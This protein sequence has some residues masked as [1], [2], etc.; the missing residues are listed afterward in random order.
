MTARPIVDLAWEW[1]D[2]PGLEC[3]R[4]EL[5]RDTIVASGIVVSVFDEKP[6]RLT[7]TLTC[8]SG[9]LFRRA[10]IELDAGAARVI[11]QIE[12]S[13]ATW[14]IDGSVRSEL[15]G[16]VD[17]DIMGS[18]ITNTLPVRRLTWRTGETRELKMAY[19]R[20]PDLEVAPALQRY[21]RLDDSASSANPSQRFTYLS[22]AS[23]F[24]AEVVMDS[25]GF[26]LHY[27]PVWRRLD[28]S[29]FAPR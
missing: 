1:L 27:P 23:G 13:D 21:T 6:L 15:E 9:W 17:I 29:Q 28:W 16:C 25:E 14:K 19:I 8:D 5:G 10:T 18:P 7:Y 11:R 22:V 12:V 20:L 3:A 26:V 4:V 2:R 24:T